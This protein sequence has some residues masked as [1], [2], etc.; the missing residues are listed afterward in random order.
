MHSTGYLIEDRRS[1]SEKYWGHR[2]AIYLK[3]IKELSNSRWENFYAALAF[4]EDVQEKMSECSKP[5]ETWTDDPNE[6]FIFGS[7]PVEEE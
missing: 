1:F 2:T 5:V 7:D 4:S 3:L 6:Y